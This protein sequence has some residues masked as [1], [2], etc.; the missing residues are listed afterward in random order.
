[1]NAPTARQVAPELSI[2]RSFDAPRALVFKVW[3][4]GEHLKRWCCPKG[5]TIPFSE[6]DIRPGGAYRSCMRSPEGEDFW[7]HGV[8]QEIVPDERISF[9]HAWENEDG[10]K[11]HETLVTITL[12]DTDAGGTR[13]TLHQSFFPSEASRDGHESGWNETLD[14]LEEHLAS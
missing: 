8:Y 3:T 7:L 11:Q 1:M 2:R 13:L 6:G 9:T 10:S 5:F 4:D 14:S 12:A